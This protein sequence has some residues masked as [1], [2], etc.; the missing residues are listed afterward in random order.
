MVASLENSTDWDTQDRL[1]DICWKIQVRIT[2]TTS[3]DNNIFHKRLADTFNFIVVTGMTFYPSKSI[4]H[5]SKIEKNRI[6]GIIPGTIPNNADAA[7]S[8]PYSIATYTKAM[9][10]M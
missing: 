2:T 4:S 5:N 7:I 10:Y 8:L 9:Q 1:L 6:Y 3:L